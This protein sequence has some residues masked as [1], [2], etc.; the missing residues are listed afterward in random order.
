M[1]SL[2][3]L[4]HA[5]VPETTRL[6]NRLPHWHP[7]RTKRMSSVGHQILNATAGEAMSAI[8]YRGREVIDN[9]FLATARTDDLSTLYAISAPNRARTTDTSHNLLKNS[10]FEWS[11]R[12]DGLAWH[13]Y[14]SAEYIAGGAA[15]DV[16][17]PTTDR[18]FY[19]GRALQAIVPQGQLAY[20]MQDIDRD[21]AA[22]QKMGLSLWYY[23]DNTL[24]A[25]DGL[26]LYA[27]GTKV[28]DGTVI[29]TTATWAE[30][31]TDSR[32]M[33]LTASTSFAHDV[34]DVKFVINF[35]N[36]SSAT[37]TYV[38]DAAQLE[39]GYDVTPWRIAFDDAP[40]FIDTEDM[41]P[42]DVFFADTRKRRC[43]Y[44]STIDDF[45]VKS[46]PTRAILGALSSNID[47]RTPIRTHSNKIEYDKRLWTTEFTVSGNQIVRVN[48]SVPD[49]V[50]STYDFYELED[51]DEM[52]VNS[53]VTV[54]DIGVF[55]EL[56]YVL[57][58]ENG[59][60]VLKICNPEMAEPEIS[61]LYVIRTI[62]IDD[63]YGF[64]SETVT[65]VTMEQ[66]IGRDNIFAITV[67][68][69]SAESARFGVTLKFDYYIHDEVAHQIITRENYN[70]DGGI[71][72]V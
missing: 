64:L 33:R 60:Y 38:V 9:M 31:S 50:Y 44:C 67:E 69:D 72:V 55:G 59:Q 35:Y 23:G 5:Y 19:G 40:W 42:Y 57:A 14:T 43:I 53:G 6:A 48:S 51:S 4:P 11:P 62:P 58:E 71:I 27:I 28:S 45:A 32:F 37:M 52:S 41:G 10:A 47:L 13:W 1:S 54:H 22:N 30:A 49:E 66:A 56:L 36:A 46:V 25:G 26:R 70:L 8:S 20:I 21:F 15:T 24:S 63:P 34:T 7:I 61:Y 29:T 12:M 39:V 3:H 16:V 18:S 2:K 68:Y 65:D 17:V